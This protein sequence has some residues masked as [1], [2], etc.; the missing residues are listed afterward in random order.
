LYFYDGGEVSLN[1]ETDQFLSWVDE[2]GNRKIIIAICEGPPFYRRNNK[3]TV[4][5][6]TRGMARGRLVDFKELAK[7]RSALSLPTKNKDD[8]KECDEFWRWLGHLLGLNREHISMFYRSFTWAVS[9]CTEVYN[10]FAKLSRCPMCKG[11]PDFVP[12]YL[13]REYVNGFEDKDEPDFEPM[14]LLRDYMN[15]FE[16]EDE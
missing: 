14:Y 16:D 12:M 10:T 7:L 8:R 2:N 1:G 3:A 13:L 6:E 4:I 9:G 15:R 5:Y 11:F